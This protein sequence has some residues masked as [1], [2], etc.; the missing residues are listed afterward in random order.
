MQAES[1][2]VV[3]H[4]ASVGPGLFVLGLI[5]RNLLWIQVAECN[6][7]AGLCWYFMAPQ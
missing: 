6:H 5:L 4:E 3:V 7:V 2:E 1:L